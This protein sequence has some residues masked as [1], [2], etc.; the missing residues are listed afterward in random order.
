MSTNDKLTLKEFFEFTKEKVKEVTIKNGGSHVPI[1]FTG[2]IRDGRLAGHTALFPLT[3]IAKSM[4]T[5][6]YGAAS[7]I[8]QD[9]GGDFMLVIITATRRTI[10]MAD[11]TPEQNEALKSGTLNTVTEEMRSKAEKTEDVVVVFLYSDFMSVYSSALVEQGPPVKVGEF[12]DMPGGEERGA[13][14][15]L[16]EEHKQRLI[17]FDFTERDARSRIEGDYEVYEVANKQRTEE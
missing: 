17:R 15:D 12:V 8:M 3:S 16:W 7:T 9:I 10:R 1:L 2:S 11:L 14:H 13:W 4:N 5:D 6:I